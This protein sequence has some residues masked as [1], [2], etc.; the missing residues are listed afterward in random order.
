MRRRGI[1]HPCARARARARGIA[2]ADSVCA[3]AIADRLR[4]VRVV[5]AVQR[6]PATVTT[7]PAVTASA[8]PGA[9][10]RIDTI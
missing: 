6:D 7:I 1:A 10:A 5:A 8:A 3:A 2:D 4:C 9:D